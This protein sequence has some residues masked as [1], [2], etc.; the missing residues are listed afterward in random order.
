MGALPGDPEV[1][2]PYSLR[3][4]FAWLQDIPEQI[5]RAVYSR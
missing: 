5:E 2:E 3:D 4:A 1:V